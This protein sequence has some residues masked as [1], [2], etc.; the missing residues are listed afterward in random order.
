MKVIGFG[1]EGGIN[2]VLR[3]RCVDEKVV[4][5]KA[6]L[7]LISKLT[8]FQGEGSAFDSMLLKIMGMACSDQL[9]SIR[10]AAISALF[11]VQ[12]L[13]LLSFLYDLNKKSFLNSV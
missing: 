3:K 7:V 2:D 11:E 12:F 10:K 8:T 13:F 5:R 4:V 6:A 1:E 9:V